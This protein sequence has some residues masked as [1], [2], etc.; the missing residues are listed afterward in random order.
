MLLNIARL[1]RAGRFLTRFSLWFT[2]YAFVS[3][4]S[5]FDDFF[6]QNFVTVL[7]ILVQ[8]AILLFFPYRTE[9]SHTNQ[10]MIV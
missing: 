9:K 5:Y 6:Q 3:K 4:G 7:Y 10:I 2:L 8:Y 1:S